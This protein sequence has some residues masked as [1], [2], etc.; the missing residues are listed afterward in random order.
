[1]KLQHI[2]FIAHIQA[3]A[4]DEVL[5]MISPRVIKDIKRTDPTP[6]FKAFCIGQEG[7]AN[8]KI[9]GVGS[10]TQR[11]YQA[12]IERLTSKMGLGISA[13][14]NHA[15]TNAEP[16]RQPIGEIVGKAM[17]KING[18]L[19]SVA[20]AYIFPQFRDLPLDIASVEADVNVPFGS[21]EFDVEDVDVLGVTGIAL[22]N[23][24]LNKPAFAGATLLATI[25][26][27]TEDDQSDEKSEPLKLGFCIN[28]LG[29]SRLTLDGHR[30]QD[31]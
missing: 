6:V 25:Q 7:E 2:K 10:T 3:M 19:S 24:L 14:H 21:R 16:N 12:A 1:M 22:G 11:W 5:A 23:S 29:L 8:P 9:V 26:A 13:F 20:V 15:A 28:P 17:K 30:R 18:F 31:A 27:M 4:D